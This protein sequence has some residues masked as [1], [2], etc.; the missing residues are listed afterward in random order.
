MHIFSPD[1]STDTGVLG[2]LFLT[3]SRLA[4]RNEF[5][6]EIMDLGGLQLMLTA[7]EQNMD[8]QVRN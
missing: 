5:C 4:V 2:E 1:Y 6:Q 8:H 3:L 7:M